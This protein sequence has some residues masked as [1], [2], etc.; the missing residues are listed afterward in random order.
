MRIL[1]VDDEKDLV[2]A[3]KQLLTV[4]KYTVDT[5]YDGES[6]LDMARGSIYDVLVVDVMLPR[7][8]GFELVQTLRNEGNVTPILLL[9][10]RDG[11]DDRVQGLDSGAD[12]Y[13][14]KPFSIKELLARVRALG[15]RNGDIV[16]VQMI[17]V[18]DFA[19]D[20]MNRTLMFKKE[21][22]TLTHKELQLF[23][24]F[25]RNPGQVLT[26][27]VIFDRIWGYDSEADSNV[28]E[29]Y[30]HFLRK[31]LNACLKPISQKNQDIG[32][33]TVR[34]IGY[35]FKGG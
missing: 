35:V 26:K 2:K 33:Q 23:E 32:I 24:L 7:I 5:A 8:S 22:V 10:A 4:E 1:V 25:M 13:L 21:N 16:G 20:L 9:S 19:L 18:G 14:I 3:L 30:I 34:G 12:D 27:D 17:T 15:R 31:K 11:I 28:V 29:A 6:G